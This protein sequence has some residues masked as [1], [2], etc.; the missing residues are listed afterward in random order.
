[1]IYDKSNIKNIKNFFESEIFINS[2]RLKER[3]ISSNFPEFYSFILK[4]YSGD[5]FLEK[6]FSFYKGHH[7]CYCGNNTK[8]I[9]FKN[10]YLEYCGYICSSNSDKTRNKYKE[11]CIEKY[12]VDNVSKSDVIKGLKSNTN[13]SRY[14]VSTFLQ[15]KSVKDLIVKRYGVDN[16]FKLDRVKEKIEETNIRK[17]GNKCSLLSPEIIKKTKKTNMEKYGVDHFSKTIEW[18]L[19]IDR[20]NK[21]VYLKKLNLSYDYLFISKDSNLNRIKHITCGEDFQIQSQ[22]IRLRNN[23][24]SE[25][26]TVCNKISSYKESELF[27]FIKSVTNYDIEKYRDNKYEIDIYIP[28]LK[29]GFE[30]NGL[31][32]HSE[33]FKHQKYHKNKSDYFE[34]MGIRIVHIWEDDWLHRESI[35]KSVIMSILNVYGDVIYARNCQFVKLSDKD[36]RHFLDEN[37]LQ[38]WCVSKYRFGLKHKDKLV[39]IMTFGKK[40]FNGKDMSNNL[41]L[42]RYSNITNV[43]IIG[44]FSKLFKNSLNNL[45]F[46]KIITYSDSSIFTGDVY[47]KNGF[48]LIGNTDPGYQYIIGKNRKNRFSY[49]KQKLIKMGY[50]KNKTEREIMF[51]KEFFRIYDCGNLKFEFT[52]F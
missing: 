24:N 40:R 28:S 31:Y 14:G 6:I 34:K 43:R 27:N 33:L 41:E 1:M 9:D 35:I 38:G 48:K 19:L 42:I 20:S 2:N 3:F 45:V 23:N 15:S 32:W 49:T 17:Y 8:F 22:L 4:Y 18:S 26:C 21:S 50:D 10:G 37:H 36:V 29:L 47:V 46:D 12:G 25:L 44:G 7:K 39:S 51:D 13:I 30:F 16:V 5:S 52:I 11:S